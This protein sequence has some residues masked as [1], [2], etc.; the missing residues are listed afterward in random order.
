MAGGT[1]CEGAGLGVGTVS[2]GTGRAAGTASEGTGLAVGTACEGTGLVA[3]GTGL[4][5][6]VV[7]VGTGLAVG[8]ACTGAGLGAGLGKAWE[9]AG[10]ARRLSVDWRFITAQNARM[11]SAVTGLNKSVGSLSAGRRSGFAVVACAGGRM[12][13]ATGVGPGNAVAGARWRKQR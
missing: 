5:L 11:P 2:G 9:G 6:E 12:A 1:V 4:A 7:C 10:L 8:T 13:G 3:E